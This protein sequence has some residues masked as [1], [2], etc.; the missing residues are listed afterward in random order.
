MNGSLGQVEDFEFLLPVLSASPKTTNSGWLL[1]ESLSQADLALLQYEV[2]G[3]YPLTFKSRKSKVSDNSGPVID[4]VFCSLSALEYTQALDSRF[5]K[6]VSPH[7]RLEFELEVPARQPGPR[8]DP[9]GPRP[10]RKSMAFN[11]DQILEF[12]HTEGLVELATS[13]GDFDVD[14][15]YR[16]IMQ[17]VGQYTVTREVKCGGGQVL[18]TLDPGLQSIKQRFR[19]IERRLRTCKDEAVRDTL[20]RQH[21]RLLET[22][23]SERDALAAEEKR[24]VRERFWE[25]KKSSN[26]HLAWKIAR[27]G[28]S[29]KGGGVKT[30]TTTSVSKEQWEAHFARLFTTS[31]GAM[32]DNVDIGSVVDAELDS[33]FQDW[34][35]TE[36]LEGKRNLKA[37]GPDG[38]RV[39]FLRLVRYDETVC[40]ALANFFTIII[41]E[42][43]VP[44]EWDEAYLFV[45][46]K[47]KGDRSDPNNYRGITLKSHFLKLLEAV[48]CARFV[49]WLDKNSLL[50]DEQLA[51]RKG[52]S[53]TDHLFTLHVLR[54]DAVRKGQVLYVGF[55]DLT[56]AFPSVNRVELLGDLVNEGASQRVV[57]LFKRLYTLDTFRLL[58]DGVP[59]SLIFCV[60]SGV[61]E[62]SCLSPTLFIFFI[63]DLPSELANS[64]SLGPCVG[65]RKLFS[66]FFADDVTVF[67]FMTQGT[68][69]LVC[70]AE[71]FFERKQLTP[72]PQ[73]SEFVAFTGKR[74][75]VHQQWVI[76]GVA[77]EAQCSVRYLGLV[78]Q[79][80]GKWNEQLSISL[81][82]ARI[83]LGRCKI[84]CRTVGLHNLKYLI[85][86]FDSVVT[87]VFRFGLGVWGVQCAQVSKLD[88]LFVEFV[89]W[90]F[91]LPRTTG[92]NGILTNF[93]RRC[94][95]CDA[96][97]L[98]SVQVAQGT[99]TR[100]AIWQSVAAGL[101]SEQTRSQWY[102]IVKAE[103]GKRDLGVEVFERGSAFVSD[104]KTHAIHF[105]QYCFHTHSNVT[106]GNSA[107]LV[108][109]KR[110]FGIFPFLFCVAPFQSRYLLAFLL[111]CWKYLDG[112]KC[113][114]YPKICEDCD[115]ENS[116]YHVL[117]ECFL[118][119][120]LRGNF[121]HVTGFEFSFE[122]LKTSDRTVCYEMCRFGQL[123]FESLCD[124]C[125]D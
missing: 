70:T 53:G 82:R 81:T 60:V 106:V 124:L 121:Q 22:W 59:G 123:L 56:K 19:K 2:D 89:R 103:V 9:V 101:H 95:K 85:N 97:F 122:L 35:I 15:A 90:V 46:Y 98:A 61:H 42:S 62:G 64:T 43:Q 94:A 8:Q 33:P 119:E 21:Q 107:D 104:R 14:S 110:E 34:E 57:G 69:E 99:C 117:F 30:S 71:R 100:N 58:L 79:Q 55:I 73:K 112:G 10:L 18:K 26:L 44:A 108:R 17:F 120:Q 31:R 39:D 48:V 93:A 63:R 83:S 12:G 50:P 87:S 75:K 91:R 84:M 28:L 88:D 78:F 74:A 27:S 7:A 102:E 113:A 77:R 96:I 114:I 11:F 47:G 38:F 125:S 32:L 80:D 41:R 76:S 86:L 4:F 109:R 115:R 25:A 24:V 54:E 52:H 29:G 72:N 23:V 13:P 66:L 37:P 6:E 45:L 118:F 36:A 111:H 3:K 65:G 92:K 105:A 40:R 68:Q 49:A 51:Y 1:L 16:V 116:S 67:S 5:E 20:E